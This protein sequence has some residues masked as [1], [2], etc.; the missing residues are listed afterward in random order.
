MNAARVT[1]L[2]QRDL[3]AFY[4]LAGNSTAIASSSLRAARTAAAHHFGVAECRVALAIST[5]N[6]SG[7]IIHASLKPAAAPTAWGVLWAAF[8][9]TLLVVS[10]VVAFVIGLKGGA[11]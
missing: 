5:Q 8:C 4:A 10:C 2:V 11:L 7:A 6:G 3:G 1:V 9:A